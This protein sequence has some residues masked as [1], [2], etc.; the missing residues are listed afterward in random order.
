M[1]I[2]V[3]MLTDVPKG[4]FIFFHA[5]F[6]VRFNVRFNFVFNVFNFFHARF[7]RVSMFLIYFMRVSI[8]VSMLTDVPKGILNYRF[9]VNGCSM[10]D[11]Y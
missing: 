4:V 10:R 5:R 11:L 8:I 2:I 3:S 7:M 6:N 1:L 9:N